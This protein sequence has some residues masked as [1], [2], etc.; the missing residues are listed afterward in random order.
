VQTRKLEVS[1][2]LIVGMCKVGSAGWS[3]SDRPLP[4]D[5]QPVGVESDVTRRSVVILVASDQWSDQEPDL[6]EPPR[7]TSHMSMSHRCAPSAQ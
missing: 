1:P 4:D 7:F 5:A 6:I 3:V 2:E